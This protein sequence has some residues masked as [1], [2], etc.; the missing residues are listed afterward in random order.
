MTRE[1][2]MVSDFHQAFDALQS[3]TPTVIDPDTRRLRL[4][5]LYEELQEAE[6]AMH[7]GDLP[8]IAK[9]LA[10]LLYVVYGT[11]VSYGINLG[12]VFR[13]VHRSN[14][15]KLGGTR[16]ADGKWL[17]PA[18]YSPADIAPLLERQRRQP[19]T[20]DRSTSFVDRQQALLQDP[21]TPYWV[22]RLLT[23]LTHKDPVD[24]LH[25]LD[26]LHDLMQRRVDELLHPHHLAQAMPA[27][28]TDPSTHHTL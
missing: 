19:P 15:T 22:R 14:L 5:L 6:E 13:E 12:P 8:A 7:S 28:F 26:V 9:E 25:A 4:T 17:K 16:R 23:D 2:Q 20:H 11:A 3:L 24:V 18:S 21:S 27:R 1:Q 10:D